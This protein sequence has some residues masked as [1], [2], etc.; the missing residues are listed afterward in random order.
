MPYAHFGVLGSKILQWDVE[1]GE[2]SPF[3]SV[4]GWTRKNDFLVSVG[5][6][7]LVPNSERSP[8]LWRWNHSK[9]SQLYGPISS[10]NAFWAMRRK[11]VKD[12]FACSYHISGIFG[13]LKSAA[14]LTKRRIHIV[15]VEGPVGLMSNHGDN[16]QDRLSERGLGICAELLV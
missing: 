15:E 7:V 12:L 11:G 8:G 3:G 10:N 5:R 2:G 1:E 13:I 6:S 14:T 16:D 9:L 4:K